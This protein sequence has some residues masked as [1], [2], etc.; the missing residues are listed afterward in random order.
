MPDESSMRAGPEG[1]ATRADQCD[2]ASMSGSGD[3]KQL[4][5][6]LLRQKLVTNSE[7]D[8]LLDPQ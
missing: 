7:L 2:S 4:G 8:E 3:K 5:K 1:R 6:I